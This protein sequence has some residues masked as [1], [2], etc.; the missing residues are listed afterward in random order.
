MREVVRR[1]RGRG[2]NRLDNERLE[3]VLLGS[4]AR[5]GGMGLLS[6]V[7]I[8]HHAFAAANEASEEC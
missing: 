7:G 6:H 2:G 1:I 4:P 5:Y 8:A 3:R